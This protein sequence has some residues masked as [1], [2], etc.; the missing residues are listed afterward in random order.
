MCY[1]AHKEKSVRNALR[2][3]MKGAQGLPCLFER[4]M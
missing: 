3:Y 4:G 1:S 2:I